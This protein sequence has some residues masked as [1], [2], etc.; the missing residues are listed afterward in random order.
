MYKQKCKIKRDHNYEITYAQYVSPQRVWA[1]RR[2]KYQTATEGEIYEK[3]NFEHV[4]SSLG[5]ALATEGNL[6]NGYNKFNNCPNLR[7]EN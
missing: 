4:S 1:V 3:R 7:L 2:F 6:I 5:I